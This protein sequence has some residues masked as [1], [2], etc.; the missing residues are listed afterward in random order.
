MVT[1]FIVSPRIGDS[2]DGES[3]VVKSGGP[4]DT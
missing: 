2:D 3:F 4:R 1:T